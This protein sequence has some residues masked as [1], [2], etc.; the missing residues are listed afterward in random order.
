[1]RLAMHRLSMAAAAVRASTQKMLLTALIF[2]SVAILVLGK[3]DLKLIKATSDGIADGSLSVLSLLRKPIE[4]TRDAAHTIGGILAV[5]DENERLRAENERLLASQHRAVLLEVENEGLRELL[6]APRIPQTRHFTS[7][8]VIADTATPFVHTRLIDAGRNRALEPGMPVIRPEGLVGRLLS[9]SERTARLMLLTDF[10]SR[11]PVVIGPSGDR[12]IL[13]GD[14]SSEP[15]LRFLPLQ[16]RFAV[17]DDVV[18]SGQGGL[19]PPGL[20]IG[21]IVHIDEHQVSVRPNIDWTR[22]DHVSVLHFEP[23]THDSSLDIEA[24]ELFYGPQ[25][26]EPEVAAPAPETAGESA[27]TS[28]LGPVE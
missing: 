10:N 1:M 11:V 7:A 8:A 27:P 25:R 2:L 9:V 17:G 20:M 14:N 26:M 3:A 21:K 4:M 5:F 23:I 24:D 6:Q 15:K 13:E 19:L 12:A 18:T 16:P 28:E 22:L